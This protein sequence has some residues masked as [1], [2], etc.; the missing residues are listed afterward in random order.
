MITIG[1]IGTAGR[2]EDKAK[3]DK[4]SYDF[5]Y[6]S[7][8]LLIST[9]IREDYRVVSGGA[10]YADHLAVKL[11]LEGKAK[12]LTLHLPCS[13]YFEQ[14]SFWNERIEDFKHPANI[15]NYYHK[16]FIKKTGIHSTRE[17]AE[18]IIKGANVVVSPGF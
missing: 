9:Y 4:E 10:S 5:M 18:A 11:Y 3:L 8:G 7:V 1:I 12:E 16:L 14:P 2:K 6:H 15:L 17:I 13:F